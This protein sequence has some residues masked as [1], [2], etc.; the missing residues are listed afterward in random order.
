MDKNVA[1]AKLE[2]MGRC[3]MRINE[4]MPSS[5]DEL[6]NDIDRQD[7][8]L[9]NLERLI[10]QMVDL[11][12]VVLADYTS[13]RPDSM[14]ES[15]RM[16]AEENVIENELAENLAR[17]VGFRNIAVHEYQRLNW[18]IVWTIIHERLDDFK[19]FAKKIDKLI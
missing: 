1:L 19:K 12:L 18:N 7:I 10:Q 9:I 16:L 14:A 8:I 17:A 3:L 6:K 5:V 4:K 11:A 13:V 15:F 2:S